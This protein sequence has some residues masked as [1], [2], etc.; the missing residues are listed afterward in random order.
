VPLRRAGLLKGMAMAAVILA[1]LGTAGA[2]HQSG[3]ERKLRA[4]FPPPG[5]M[6]DVGGR[7]LH[8]YCTGAGDGPTVVIEAGAGAFSVNHRAVQQRVAEFARVCTYD[9][10]GYGWSDPAPPGRSLVD[11]VHD[12]HAVLHLGGVPEPYVLAG[13]SMGGLLVQIYQQRYPKEVAGMVLIEGTNPNYMFGKPVGR[14]LATMG[15]GVKAGAWAVS[16]GLKP[17]VDQF[18]NVMKV[19]KGQ[20]AESALSFLAGPLRVRAED[21]AFYGK[22]LRGARY[23][24]SKGSLH[25]LPLAVVTRGSGGGGGGWNAAQAALAAMSTRSTIVGAERSGHNVNI[26]RPDVVAEAIRQV[27]ETAR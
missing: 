20:P 18:S 1:A 8:L 19:P 14:T 26:D 23:D 7:R 21:L 15:V 24:G 25:D 13:H 3:A 17:V 9:R 2:V 4:Q 11:R 6:V 22:P 16:M 12:L 10:A 5:Q 27:W